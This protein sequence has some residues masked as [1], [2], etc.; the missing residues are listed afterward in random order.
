MSSS[1]KQFTDLVLSLD[2]GAETP[3]VSTDGEACIPPSHS[4]SLVRG[5]L[6]SIGA[7]WGYAQAR[8]RQG[9]LDEI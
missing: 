4:L 7:G 5:F 8:G 2:N 3:R 9:Q 1:G 6:R